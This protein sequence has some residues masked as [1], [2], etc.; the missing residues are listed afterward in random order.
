MPELPT[1]VYCGDPVDLGKPY[2]TAR[3]REASSVPLTKG[4]LPTPKDK[5][6]S[7]T[8]QRSRRS[9][10]LPSNSKNAKLAHVGDCPPV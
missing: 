2:A 3:P 10:R 5:N 1:C 6:Q 9:T 8:E 7:V 4:L